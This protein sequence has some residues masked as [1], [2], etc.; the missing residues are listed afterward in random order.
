MAQGRRPGGRRTSRGP[1]RRRR[2]GC[3]APRTDAWRPGRRRA[4]ARTAGRLPASLSSRTAS[5]RPPTMSSVGART[6]ASGPRR[7]RAGHRG[8]PPRRRRR[9]GSAAA[10]SAAPAPVLAPKQPTGRTRQSGWCR[11]HAVT[12]GEPAGQQPMSKTAGAVGLLLGREQVEQQRR[13]A[14]AAAA[15]RRRSGCAG[16]AGCCRCR[17]RRPPARRHARGTVRWPA[18]STPAGR[19]P[20][21][22]RPGV[23]RS[24]PR[25]GRRR[26]GAS[27]STTS[28]SPVGAEVGVDLA[29][30]GEVRR[31]LQA[32]SA[33]RRPRPAAGR[34]GAHRDGEHDARGA[35]GPAPRAGGTR[36]RAGRDPVVDDDGGPAGERDPRPAPRGSAARGPRS[37]RAPAAGPLRAPPGSPRSARGR[38]RS[39]T[40]TP[41]SPT[42][43]MASSGRYGTPTL[44]TTM[45]SS[46]A[47]RA[48]AISAATGTPP[49]GSPRTTTS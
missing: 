27:S 26:P 45:T 43:P 11:T 41:P 15:R 3:P 14:G 7:G 25:A 19:G 40:R 30:G 16:C 20:R 33:R 4:R 36:R 17:G 48:R 6:S 23:G 1:A 29:D 13:Q 37:R 35:R 42:A 38:R 46:G 28:S 34:P 47:S 8:T 22:P 31:R 21:R 32:R 2:R 39:A 5:S 24:A 9:P 10:H 18:R 49:R 44:R 12:R